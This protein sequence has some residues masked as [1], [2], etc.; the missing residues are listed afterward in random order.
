[1]TDLFDF[2]RDAL[3]YLDLLVNNSASG[4]N[5]AAMDLTAHHWD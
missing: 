4:V 5:R 2:V 1:V 3:G